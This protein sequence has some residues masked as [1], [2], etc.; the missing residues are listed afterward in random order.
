MSASGQTDTEL[1]NAGLSRRRSSDWPSVRFADVCDIQLGKMLSPASRQGLRPRKYLRNANVQWGRFDLEDVAEMDF[2]DAQESKFT[3]RD[4]DVMVCEGGEPGRAAVWHG[5]IDGCLYQKS[6]HRLRPRPDTLDSDYLA[7]RL[8]LAAERGEFLGSHARTTIAHLPAV[9]LAELRIELPP[10]SEQKRIAA[11]LREQLDAAARMRAAVDAKAESL[12]SLAT[13][14]LEDLLAGL[15]RLECATR[16]CGDV[17]TVT[18]GIQKSPA[19]APQ[20]F[21]RPFLTVRN[22]M[23]GYLDVS[24]VERM[25]VTPAELNRLQL[26]SGDLLVVEGNGS[27]EQIG[28]NA[29]FR[30]E[31][32]GCVHQNHVIRVRP[33]RDLL[34]PD[35]LSLYLNS[36]QGM[37]QMLQRAMT[38]TGLHTLSVRKIES[39]EF[40]VPTL[41]EQN[42]AVESWAASARQLDA[43]SRAADREAAEIGRL[44]A[45][46]LRQAFVTTDS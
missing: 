23:R 45:A 24:N 10:L 34:N 41:A 27:R 5:E 46:L 26:R 43:A 16:R 17:A 28:R 13:T 2:T 33:R 9:R 30:G 22:V 32:D 3:L 18:G 36:R 4:G 6:L 21:H 15:R 20:S 31:I 44:S 40:P 11:L 39:L 1:A 14:T 7:F 25:E 19:R 37:E 35:Y 29:L 42:A 8:R 38:T 12:R